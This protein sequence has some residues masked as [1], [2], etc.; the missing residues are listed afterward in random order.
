MRP[1][2]KVL[3]NHVFEITIVLLGAI[4][5]TL[6]TVFADRN[7]GLMSVPLF[8]PC[9]G[10]M[11]AIRQELATQVG[12]TIEDRKLLRSIPE[13]RWRFD[14]QLELE[15]AYVRFTSWAGG[16][17]RVG[18]RLLAYEVKAL[19]NAAVSVRAIHLDESAAMRCDSGCNVFDPSSPG[20]TVQTPRSTISL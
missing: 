13:S 12:D 18:G 2:R 15:E 8:P 11:I 5:A 20:V 14:A 10:Q 17:R 3:S 7:V 16:T 4:I 1:V 19:S 9:C 6:E